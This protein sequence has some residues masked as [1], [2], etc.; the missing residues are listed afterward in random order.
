MARKRL[1]VHRD[2]SEAADETGQAAALVGD[3]AGSS[4]SCKSGM[5]FP[6][7]NGSICLATI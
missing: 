1:R 5:L 7:W 4:T 3:L 2:I 6:F